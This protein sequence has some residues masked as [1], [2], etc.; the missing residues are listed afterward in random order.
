MTLYTA[1]VTLRDFPNSGDEYSYL[2]SA[3]LFA[4]GKLYV[5]SPE[6]REFF[7]FFHIINNGRFYGKFP[8]GW[9]L[10]LSVGV[11]VGAPGVISA[12]L[13]SGVLVLLYRLA[14]EHFSREEADLSLAVA[15][16]NPFLVFNA[17][18]YF[19]HTSCLFFCVLTLFFALKILKDPSPGSSYVALGSSAGMA[20][21]I[22]P[23]TAFALLL[24][25]AVYVLVAVHRGMPWR[26]ALPRLSLSAVSFATFVGLLL[27][28]NAAQGADPIAGPYSQY[29][30]AARLGRV[31]GAHDWEW[32]V[33]NNLFDR[34][35]Q[36]S[37]WVPLSG[38]LLFA[39]LGGFGAGHDPRRVLLALT[40][41]GLLAGYFFYLQDPGNQYGPRYL[42]ESFA[43]L[44]LVMSFVLK[45]LGRFGLVVAVIIM[46]TNIWVLSRESRR[47]SAEVHDRTEV[48]E[49]VKRLGLR[50]AIV[51]LRTG[52]GS[53]P[54][55][56]LTRNGIS[57][58]GD[59][60]YVQDRGATNSRLLRRYP[61]RQA[62]VYSFDPA[63][64]AGSIIPYR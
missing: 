38:I 40:V 63:I 43:S 1:R 64:H 22:R 31:P 48:F 57:F 10:L 19:S 44:L 7:D 33:R 27:I 14:R 47:V 37:V 45:R 56:D 4:H 18:S 6:P 26:A 41:V 62:F 8:P 29:D 24:P 60:L 17:A 16:C 49:T 58:D 39:L 5:P 13:G 54:P 23:Y 15:F 61:D 42:F 59:V 11:L 32:A 12:L 35:Y 9:P 50:R 3:T 25:A 53:M 2:L 46:G 51:F 21:L 30:G 36:L 55:M 34:L 20:L 52:S 28:Y